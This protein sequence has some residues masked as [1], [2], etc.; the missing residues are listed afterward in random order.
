MRLKNASRSAIVCPM[1]LQLWY[2]FTMK[3]K[4]KERA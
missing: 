2:G 1:S 3:T 4:S